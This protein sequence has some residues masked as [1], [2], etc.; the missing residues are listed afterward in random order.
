MINN[1]RRAT[2]GLGIALVAFG[3]YLAGEA[4]YNN[5]N[6]P[7]THHSADAQ[8]H[9]SLLGTAFSVSDPPFFLFLFAD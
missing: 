1:F 6:S 2:P 9:W 5:F 3:I 4:A 7:K 8:D